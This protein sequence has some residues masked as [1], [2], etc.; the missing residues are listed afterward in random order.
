M[1]YKKIPFDPYRVL[2]VGREADMKDIEASH[3]RLCFRYHPNKAG[4]ESH[5][6]FFQIQEA[7]EPLSG[8]KLRS[9][10]LANGANQDDDGPDRYD[11]SEYEWWSNGGPP[12]KTH[13]VKFGSQIWATDPIDDISNKLVDIKRRF[14]ALFNRVRM[15]ISRSEMA[16]FT[17]LYRISQDIGQRNSEI[18]LVRG[19]AKRVADRHWKDTPEIQSIGDA[20]YRLRAT[21]IHMKSKVLGLERLAKQL[22]S[23]PPTAIERRKTLKEMLRIQAYQWTN[24]N[25]PR[26]G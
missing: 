4:P 3:R 19:Q 10:P 12:R 18:A 11:N 2:K 21:V 24:G 15:S 23:T 7:Y 20:L 17:P 16:M 1:P 6:K 5:E 26:Y 25:M 9:N 22:E 14:D 13:D 8:A